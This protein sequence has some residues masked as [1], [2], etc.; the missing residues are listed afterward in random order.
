[1]AGHTTIRERLEDDNAVV[2]AV[3]RVPTPT[4][5]EVYGDVGL[6]FCFLDYEHASGRG[7]GDSA[8]MEDLVRAAEVVGIDPLV[9]LPEGHPPLVRKTL[10]TGVRTL[11]IPRVETAAEVREAVAA[12]RFSYDDGVGDRGTAGTR[13]N[14]WG[15]EYE[16]YH[17]REDAATTLGVMIETADA[18][19]DLEAILTVPDL[20]FA[21]VGHRDL[22]H[23]LGYGEEIDHPEVAAT[24]AEIRDACPD[25]GVPVGRVATDPEDARAA[26]DEGY[27]VILGGY[28][29]HAVRQ[30][31]GEWAT[32]TDE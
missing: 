22:T 3:A 5:V 16:D 8:A 4:L 18:V 29:F 14:R 13:A 10:E 6:D 32:V 28:E 30:V 11:L 15:H 17:A 9:R 20:G 25:A 19:A 12:A 2:G 24:V 31:Y 7:P 23:S 21:L 1:M 26:I 27:R